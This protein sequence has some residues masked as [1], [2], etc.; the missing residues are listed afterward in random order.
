MDKKE[1]IVACIET[2]LYYH[3]KLQY[4]NKHLTRLK[5]TVFQMT[6]KKIDV[7]E[8]EQ[9]LEDLLDTLPFG[10]FVI[11]LVYDFKKHRYT[12]TTRAHQYQSA[13]INVGIS[14][15]VRHTHPENWIKSTNRKFYKEVENEAT[16]HGLN[17]MIIMNEHGRVCESSIANVFILKDDIYYTPPL[18]E[19]CI[20]GVFRAVFMQK[21]RIKKFK[22]IEKPL[23]IEDL[24]TADQVF[25]CN[26]VKKMYPVQIE[27]CTA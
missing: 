21:A 1:E 12:L 7:K 13:K 15:L 14:R 3:G 26:A 20:D 25:L 9:D 19:G 5:K 17:D 10:N 4:I 8:I 24:K 11:K 6:R 16:K 18:S 23:T 22:V 2:I 27:Y